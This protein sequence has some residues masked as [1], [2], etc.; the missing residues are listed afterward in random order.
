MNFTKWKFRLVLV[1]CRLFCRVVCLCLTGHCPRAIFTKLYIQVGI[2]TLEELITFCRS[3]ASR[4]GT[5]LTDVSTVLDRESLNTVALAYIS[6]ETDWIFIKFL[7]QM[8]RRTR[9][10]S[11][12]FWTHP[13]PDQELVRFS[14]SRGHISAET[15]CFRV[16]LVGITCKRSPTPI[17]GNAMWWFV[18]LL[19]FYTVW[20]PA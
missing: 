4:I 13:D 19:W 10:S 17:R 11:I 7:S 18:Y 8:S 6:T 9:T 12:D 2:P 14:R 1:S 15:N 16:V 5:F 3:S 20:V